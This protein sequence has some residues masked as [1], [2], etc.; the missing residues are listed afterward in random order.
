MGE[1]EGGGGR[2]K[3]FW[4]PLP[5]WGGEILLDHVFSIMDSLVIR[6]G[7]GGG[8][9]YWDGKDFRCAGAS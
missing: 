5:Q 2:E 8:T 4:S 9:Y 6:S 1:G 7:G 3:T